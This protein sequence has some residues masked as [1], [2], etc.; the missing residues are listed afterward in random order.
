MGKISRSKISSSD[1][2]GSI[3]AKLLTV[4][5]I[6]AVIVFT[7]Y[8][9]TTQKDQFTTLQISSSLQSDLTYASNQIKLFQTVDVNSNFPTA[10]NCPTPGATEVCLVSHTGSKFIYVPS[11]DTNPKTFTLDAV[12]DNDKFSIKYRITNSTNPV[13][14]SGQ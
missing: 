3:L 11:N 12:S 10:N 1:K 6:L 9:V 5:V 2:S 14:M 4:I 13:L 7:G 8:V